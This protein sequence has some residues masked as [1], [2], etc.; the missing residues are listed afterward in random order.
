MRFR[1]L[2][3]TAFEVS[4]IGFGAWGISGAQWIGADDETSLQALKT[5][6]ESGINFFDTAL[7]YGSG[8]SEQLIKRAFGKSSD[9]VIASKVP[10][11]NMIWPA[12]DG[13]PLG[14]VFP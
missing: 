1:K 10:P 5:A 7:A 8:H 14:K 2:G 11:K 12:Q 9:V 4:E 6:R 3:R 13:T